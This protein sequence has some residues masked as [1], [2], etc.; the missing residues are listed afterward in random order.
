MPAALPPQLEA[1]L[2]PATRTTWH[3]LAG[4]LVAGAYLVGGT[5]LAAH[6]GHRVSRDLDYFV[7][8]PFDPEALA[9]RL[10]QLGDFAASRIS[11]GTLNGTLDETKV[12]FLDAQDQTR[13]EPLATI[14]AMPVAGLGDL[15]ATKLNA[16]GGRGELR[17]YYDLL[18]LD[19]DAG[20]RIEEGCALFL[21]RYHPTTPQAALLHIVGALGYLTDVDDDPMLPM[22]RD[23]IEAYWAHRQPE[24]LASLDRRTI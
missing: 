3:L 15:L 19:R 9:D 13:V 4:N 16:V 7:A 12:Q 2:P 14:A 11:E 21:A 24:I 5:G 22:P 17:D 10:A 6:L 20:R 8:E 1:V 18:V 23:Q